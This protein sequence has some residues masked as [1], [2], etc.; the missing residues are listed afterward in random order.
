MTMQ[1]SLSGAEHRE[2]AEILA[3]RE[4]AELIAKAQVHA[5]LALASEV[6]DLGTGL[7]SRISELKAGLADIN[8]SLSLIYEQLVAIERTAGPPHRS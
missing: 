2:A 3:T 1:S 5:T 4:K 6:S 8:A 7:E